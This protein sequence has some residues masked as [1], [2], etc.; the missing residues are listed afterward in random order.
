VVLTGM[1]DDGARGL[2]AL[3][4]A[5]GHTLVEDQSTAVVYGMPAA[6]AN[7]GAACEILPLP[8]IAPRL[9]EITAAG[10]RVSE[11]D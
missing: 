2:L 3:R 6:A 4:E 8:E 11:R 10:A 7:L 5:G 1:G 9:L